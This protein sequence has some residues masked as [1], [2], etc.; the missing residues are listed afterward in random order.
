MLSKFNET[1]DTSDT[2]QPIGFHFNTFPKR[3][4]YLYLLKRD[5]LRST[6]S[7]NVILYPC[8]QCILK[9]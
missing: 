1:R 6:V 9:L 3:M 7:V 4:F 8:D 2:V 5:V